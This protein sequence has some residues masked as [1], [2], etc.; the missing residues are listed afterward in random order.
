MKVSEIYDF[1]VEGGGIDLTLILILKIQ[2]L[3]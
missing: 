1:F 2:K 3:N